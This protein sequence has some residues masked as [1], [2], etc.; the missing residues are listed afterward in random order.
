MDL[1]DAPHDLRRAELRDDG[2]ERRTQRR[3]P[4]GFAQGRPA[5]SSSPCGS[6]HAIQGD[7][8]VQTTHGVVSA[9]KVAIDRRRFG[10]GSRVR[11]GLRSG[12]QDRESILVGALR[13]KDPRQ[14]QPRLGVVRLEREDPRERAASTPPRRPCPSATRPACGAPRRARGASQPCAPCTRSLPGRR[15]PP[16]LHPPPHAMPDGLQETR[17]R[18]SSRRHLHPSAPCLRGAPAMP[19][20]AMLPTTARGGCGWL[21]DPAEWDDGT[22]IA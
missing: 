18:S 16:S 13:A 15:P 20:R 8:R 11:C 21:R 12:D 7:G 2:G 4:H 1:V 6:V 10:E 17:R 5:P 14:P 19:R 3:L 22:E 9:A